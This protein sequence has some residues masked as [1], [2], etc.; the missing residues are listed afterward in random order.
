MNLLTVQNLAKAF[1]GVCA[2]DGVDFAL[3]AGERL[4]LIG[5][6]GA[7]KS[8]TFAMLGGQ[9]KPDAGS[10]QLAGHELAGLAP[11]AICRLGVGR[12][13]QIAQPFAS[14]SVAENVQLALISADGNVFQPWRR[15]ARYRRADALALLDQV[16]MVQQAGQPCRALSYGD[17]KRVELAIALAHAPRLLLLDE[18]TAGMAPD[19]SRALMR[20]VTRLTRQRGLTTLFT[21]HNMDAVFAHAD[22]I[23]VMARGRVIAQGSPAAIV[24]DPVVREAYLGD[25]FSD[26]LAQDMED[27]AP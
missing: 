12:T 4:A 3:A 24:A 8:T 26:A 22:R 9:I 15:A 16:G 2:V 20:L 19:E 27:E 21:E 17:I 10:I 1:G 6:N 14:F 5:P 13:F 23:L 25:D 7:G 18:P 11:R